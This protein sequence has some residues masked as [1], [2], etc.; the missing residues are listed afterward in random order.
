MLLIER[1]QFRPGR[2]RFRSRIVPLANALIGGV[3]LVIALGAVAQ[4]TLA[5]DTAAPAK[6]NFIREVRPI[7]AKNCF[8]CHGPD[9]AKRAKGLRLDLRE[10][11]IKP[12]QSGDAA[13]VPGDSDSSTLYL[14]ITEEDETLRMPPRK[15]SERLGKTDAE[16]LRRW[17]EQ[18]AV[19]ARHWS[20][21]PPRSLPLPQVRETA[22]PRNGIDFWILAHLE[23]EGLR[24]SPEADRHL[25]LHRV[26]L[27]LRGLPPGPEEVDRF[28]H[29]S[30]PM[31]SRRPST[32]FWLIQ[33]MASGGRECGWI[34]RTTP[35]RPVTGQTP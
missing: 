11:A 4:P 14:R 8:A 1:Y 19:Y 10:S 22:W 9:E 7:L 12:L 13:I 15:A 34:S 18:G 6:V 28:I 33:R 26:S 17:V 30:A 25:L 29:D 32:A 20:L 3:L 23:K 31:L 16:I 21:V 24:P 5:D 35:T 27:D 2:S